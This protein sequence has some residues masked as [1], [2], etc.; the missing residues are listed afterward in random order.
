[1]E[2]IRSVRVWS[3]RRMLTAA[4]GG[5]ASVAWRPSARADA[6]TERPELGTAFAKEGVVGTFALYDGQKDALTLV[7]PRR[8]AMRY[9]PAS[10][11]KIANSVIALETGAV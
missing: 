3:R 2:P 11:F 10:T 8:A 9:V 6:A 7:E 1:M 5:A 4:V